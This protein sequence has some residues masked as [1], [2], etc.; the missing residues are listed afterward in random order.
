MEKP[1]KKV[2]L[3][4]KDDYESMRNDTLEFAKEKYLNGHSDTRSVQ[5]NTDLLTSLIQDSADNI[6][7]R[8]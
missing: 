2:F 6:S 8:N 1:R 3:Y 5:E 7:H 4:H